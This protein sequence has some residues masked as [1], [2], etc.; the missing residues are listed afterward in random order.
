MA[1]CQSQEI[2]EASLGMSAFM[3][4]EIWTGI[5]FNL[6]AI[7]SIFTRLTQKI[8]KSEIE[9]WLYSG[10]FSQFL[11]GAPPVKIMIPW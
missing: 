10:N 6:E 4:Q 2:C 11:P 9:K 3:V 5:N 1:C 8:G 7:E